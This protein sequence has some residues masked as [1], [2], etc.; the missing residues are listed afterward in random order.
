MEDKFF[1]KT[2]NI[3]LKVKQWLKGLFCSDE[4]VKGLKGNLSK[5]QT[6]GNMQYSLKFLNFTHLIIVSVKPI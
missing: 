5:R 6:T 1:F 3:S 2:P 4:A